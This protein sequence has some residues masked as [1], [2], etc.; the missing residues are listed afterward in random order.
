MR[1]VK[2]T[3]NEGITYSSRLNKISNKEER[4]K[5]LLDMCHNYALDITPKQMAQSYLLWYKTLHRLYVEIFSDLIKNENKRRSIKKELDSFKPHMKELYRITSK[6]NYI[7]IT[8]LDKFHEILTNI[9]CSI[10][11]IIDEVEEQK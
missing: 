1:V 7:D 5:R 11:I 6:D 8:I 3:E 2:E 4:I 10:Q 9:N